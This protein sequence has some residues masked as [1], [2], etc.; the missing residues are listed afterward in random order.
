[1]PVSI[2]KTGKFLKGLKTFCG[3]DETINKFDYQYIK[4]K[5]GT[6]RGTH[7]SISHLYL[8]AYSTPKPIK[9]KL[10]TTISLY[11]YFKNHNQMK[12]I[13]FIL[14]TL[15]L[16]NSCNKNSTTT[17]VNNGKIN[18]VCNQYNN[19]NT[20]LERVA[21]ENGKLNITHKINANDYVF[22]TIDMSN[23]NYKTQSNIGFNLYSSN[24]TYQTVD[25]DA[26]GKLT[27]LSNIING[28]INGRSGNYIEFNDY[29]L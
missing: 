8:S 4:Y 27:Y 19:M 12:K 24:I 5:K 11:L 17:A 2:K 10:L 6:K 18:F 14:S 15:I 7:S 25:F 1:M 13:I 26:I 21:F 20:S 3:L 28:R 29:R 9:S 22:H 16:L 23:A